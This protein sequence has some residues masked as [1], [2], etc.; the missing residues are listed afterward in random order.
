MAGA[1]SIQQNVTLAY[2]GIAERLGLALAAAATTLVAEHQRRINIANP[3]PYKTPSRRGEYPKKRTGFGQANV[4][5][6]PTS[7]GEIGKQQFVDVGY[8]ANA[9]YMQWLHDEHNRKG[10]EE[11]AKDM[12]AQLQAVV[13]RVA[14]QQTGGG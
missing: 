4:M 10:I 5:Y 3:R 12:N 6:Q 9:F 1:A 11:T 7:P 8:A 2:K 14:Q 13:A